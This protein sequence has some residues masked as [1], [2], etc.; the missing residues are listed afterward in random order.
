MRIVDANTVEL[1]AT[2]TEPTVSSDGSPLTDLDYS[3]IYI[4]TPAGT[5][6]APAIQESA[7]TGGGVRAVKLLVDAPSNAKTTL[8]FAASSTDTAGNEGPRTA[9]VTVVIDR[10]APAAPS[11][12]TV[13]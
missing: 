5:L 3:T 8:R 13:A 9:E 4:I 11:S 7:A 10:I 2:F 1:D 6:K 12:F